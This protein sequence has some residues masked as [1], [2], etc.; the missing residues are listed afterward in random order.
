[1]I[2]KILILVTSCFSLIAAGSYTIYP[3]FLSLLSNKFKFSSFEV[4]LF[5]TTIDLGYYIGLPMG[6]LYDKYG[7][8]LSLIISGFLI[9]IGYLLLQILFD[10]EEVIQIQDKYSIIPFI[11]IGFL[12]G[13]GSVLL[14]IVSITINLK[15][16]KFKE[17][18]A[19]L[20][21]LMSN[22]A[23]SGSIFS[24]YKK[25]AVP[26]ITIQAFFTY[27]IC[28]VSFIILI[29][30]LLFKEVK[31][32]DV[33][34]SDFHKYKEKK[35][36][37]ILIYFNIGIILLYII[38]LIINKYSNSTTIP[39]FIIFPILKLLNFIVIIAEIYKCWDEELFRKYIDKQALKEQIKRDK[40]SQKEQERIVS[41]AMKLKK[42]KEKNEKSMIDEKKAEKNV[43]LNEENV[44][45]DDING[46]KVKENLQVEEKKE[47]LI[48]NNSNQIEDNKNENKEIDNENQNEDINNHQCEENDDTP[49]INIIHE[50]EI[51]INIDN[52]NNQINNNTPNP[53]QERKFTDGIT[54]ISNADNENIGNQSNSKTETGRKSR[55]ESAKKQ[56][57]ARQIREIISLQKENEMISHNQINEMNINLDQD[58]PFK[59]ILKSHIIWIVFGILFICEG[60]ILSNINNINYIIESILLDMKQISIEELSSFVYD[61]T[62]IFFVFNSLGRLLIGYTMTG[63]IKSNNFYWLIVVVSF[64][65]L[66]SQI[67]GIFLNSS[68]MFISISFLGVTQAGLSIFVT[69]FIRIEYGVKSYGKV[70]G[71][72]YIAN[73]FGIVFISNLLFLLFFNIY[74]ENNN[75]SCLGKK[76]FL[77]GYIINIVLSIVA[78]CLSL[79]LYWIFR[80]KNSLNKKRKNSHEIEVVNYKNK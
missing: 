75:E 70:Y 30:L 49:S 69:L 7:H 59:I 43:I 55:R 27:I 4:N 26:E 23:I 40:N 24:S 67:L 58:V 73:S 14:K 50:N 78:F 71:L 33:N 64:I 22:L 12:I 28:F 62:I 20:G 39:N 52:Q 57:K 72:L 19:M 66:T 18:S 51:E 63:F 9:S 38:G 41:K 10:R 2:H 61:Y 76:C 53:S 34:Y 80:K 44:K 37:N 17:T 54:S 79:W 56:I 25:E 31:K 46:E 21:L 74:K 29:C 1:M 47:E 8:R 42:I 77:G 35:M 32:D 68:T 48:M 60:I 45:S 36:V 15:N 6:L 16:F 11:I 13:Q 5:A 65:L 3:L